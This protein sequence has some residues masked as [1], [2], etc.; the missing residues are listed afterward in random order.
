KRSTS[1]ATS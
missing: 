1:V